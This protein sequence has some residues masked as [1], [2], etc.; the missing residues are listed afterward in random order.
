MVEAWTV[1]VSMGKIVRLPVNNLPIYYCFCIPSLFSLHTPTRTHTI[2]VTMTST[3]HPED[4]DMTAVDT[5]HTSVPATDQNLSVNSSINVEELC[6]TMFACE[7]F[8]KGVAE[9]FASVM[10][11]QTDWEDVKSAAAKSKG[12]ST[13]PARS[14]NTRGPRKGAAPSG[15]DSFRAAER[16]AREVGLNQI[17]NAKFGHGIEFTLFNTDGSP[18]DGSRPSGIFGAEQTVC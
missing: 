12:F 2:S 8:Q 9:A 17:Q 4:E 7:T 16:F 5:A 6:K 10:S 1:T 11:K 13:T 18:S 15:E 3:V 14:N